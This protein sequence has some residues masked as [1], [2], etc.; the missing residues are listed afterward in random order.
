MKT[1]TPDE[2]AYGLLKMRKK[3][4]KVSFSAAVR[5]VMPMPGTLGAFLSFVDSNHTD[6]MAGNEVLEQ[7]VEDRSSKK[8]DLWS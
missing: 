5:K 3:G 7:I 1:I 8:E 4:S 6:E 2:E